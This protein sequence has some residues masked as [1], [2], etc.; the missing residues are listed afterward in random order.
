MNNT[1]KWSAANEQKAKKRF[2]IKSYRPGQR[3]LIEAIMEGSDALGILPT[4][5]GKSL[6]YQLPALFFSRAV[7]VVSP[8]ISLMQD[9]HEKLSDNNIAAVKLNSTLNAAGE[10]LMLNRMTLF[11]N[12]TLDCRPLYDHAS[13]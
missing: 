4:G 10:T 5:G 8:L 7:L 9:Q 1:W 12:S 11:H 13:R 6:C 3:E 2:G